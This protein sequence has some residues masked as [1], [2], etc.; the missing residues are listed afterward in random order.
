MG[1]FSGV[2][3]AKAKTDAN[4]LNPGNYIVRINQVKQTQNKDKCD[5]V[6]A[7]MTVLHAISKEDGHPGHSAGED[8]S[9]VFSKTGPT[10]GYFLPELKAFAA[11]C[12]G[13]PATDFDA[14]A[15]SE[16]EKEVEKF[17]EEMVSKEQPLAGTIVEIKN[18]DHITK[19]GEHR[20]L[21]TFKRRVRPSA[22]LAKDAAA[23][24]LLD[25][26]AIARFFAKGELDR[27]IALEK[28]EDANMV[29][30]AA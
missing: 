30:A 14:P 8:I 15:G 20:T 27:L 22:I 6:V 23:G 24:G 17:F 10:A 19:K 18:R 29:A 1:L 9:K 12:I 5:I 3:S 28:S 2:G 13:C 4:Y 25:D 21:C 11:A 7:E 16:A 26:K